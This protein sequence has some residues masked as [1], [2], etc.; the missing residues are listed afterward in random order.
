MKIARNNKP[1]IYRW[2]F[3]GLGKAKFN[4]SS[5]KDDSCF[6]RNRLE[7]LD[8]NDQSI[9][10]NMEIR[11]EKLALNNIKVYWWQK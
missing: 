10:E 8:F 9:G 1:N 6:E 3:F 7:Q 5:N 2:N 11:L 4:C